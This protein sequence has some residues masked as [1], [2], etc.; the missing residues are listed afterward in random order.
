MEDVP[1]FDV[2]MLDANEGVDVVMG[3]GG[4]DVE[5][6]KVVN[7]MDIDGDVETEETTDRTSRTATLCKVFGSTQQE[8]KS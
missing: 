2:E 7:M 3:G 6:K 8:V 1:Y 4:K 5:M